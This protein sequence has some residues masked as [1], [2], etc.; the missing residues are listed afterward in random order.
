MSEKVGYMGPTISLPKGKTFADT[1]TF[2]YMAA[3]KYFHGREINFPRP[4]GR[5]F[6]LLHQADLAS[7]I[8]FALHCN[9]FLDGSL[10]DA[11]SRHKVAR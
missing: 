4:Y 9:V 8:L 6:S 1:T 3:Q 7:R 2:G 10:I 5:G 11:H